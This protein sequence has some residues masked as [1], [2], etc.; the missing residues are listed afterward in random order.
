MSNDELELELDRDEEDELDFDELGPVVGSPGGPAKTPPPDTELPDE[1]EVG[2]NEDELELKIADDADDELELD[3]GSGMAF[4][5]RNGVLGTKT[6]A[7]ERGAAGGR[8]PRLAVDDED[9][10]EPPFHVPPVHDLRT[11]QLL[12]QPA[13]VLPRPHV[14][15]HIQP[16][17]VEPR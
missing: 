9:V 10:V 14:F 12:L 8:S 5:F 6:P 13:G 1:T 11:G 2:S 17:G 7:V 4:A 3:D 15:D 16:A